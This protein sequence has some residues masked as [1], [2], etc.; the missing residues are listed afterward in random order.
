MVTVKYGCSPTNGM[1]H[2]STIWQWRSTGEILSSSFYIIQVKL[3]PSHEY[4]TVAYGY[5]QVLQTISG[6]TLVR[7]CCYMTWSCLAHK[8][9]APS[10][11]SL[12]SICQRVGHLKMPHTFWQRRD[13]DSV[14]HYPVSEAEAK[15]KAMSHLRA[16]ASPR[17]RQ[18]RI[19][20]PDGRSC[21]SQVLVSPS[22]LNTAC[23]CA[24]SI[25]TVPNVDDVP[26]L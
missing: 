13:I 7:F 10:T 11:S 21:R 26:L 18:C 14:M 25:Y 22:P 2:L 5:E 17:R 6:V 8:L 15:A 4:T 9:S 1:L 19:H 3:S 12:V 20:N 16:A 23:K 24:N